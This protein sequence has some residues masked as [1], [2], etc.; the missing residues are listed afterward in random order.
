[1]DTCKPTKSNKKWKKCR[2]P[3]SKINN[4]EHHHCSNVYM[5]YTYMFKE[6]TKYKKITTQKFGG[7]LGPWDKLVYHKH[8][9]IIC[10]ASFVFGL[11]CHH[12]GGKEGL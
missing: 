11:L 9:K 7:P 6:I 10:R 3:I 5:L 2:T 4:Q 1:M 12:G 8:K